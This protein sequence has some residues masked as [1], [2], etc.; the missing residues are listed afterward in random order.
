MRRT[1]IQRILMDLGLG[2]L[3]TVGVGSWGV[4][5]AAPQALAADLDS[6]GNAS[7]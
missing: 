4:A 2:A 5:G 6:V 7:I 1:A 3:P